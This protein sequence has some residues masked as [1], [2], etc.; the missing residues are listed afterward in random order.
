MI[1]KLQKRVGLIIESWTTQKRPRDF[2]TTSVLVS[3]HHSPI[4]E[5]NDFREMVDY[6]SGIGKM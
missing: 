5:P 6:R 4:K 3:K 2:P 1:K